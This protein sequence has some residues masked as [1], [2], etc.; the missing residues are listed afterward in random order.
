M[1]LKPELFNKNYVVALKNTDRRTTAGK[2]KYA[3]F[4]LESENKTI[5][6]K[7]VCNS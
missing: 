6:T 2:E 3:E 5:L 7:S 1:V 4:A